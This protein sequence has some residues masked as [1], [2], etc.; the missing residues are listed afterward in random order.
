MDA[1][2]LAAYQ[3]TEYR[4]RDGAYAF[5][6]RVEEPSPLLQACQ[7][8][9]GVTCSAFL[10]ACNPHSTPTPRDVNEAAMARLE[11]DLAGMGLRWLRGMGVDPAGDWPGEP[12]LLV[13]GLDQPAGVALARRLAQNAIVC[14]AADAVPHL[15]I[16]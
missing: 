12:S 10:T 6:M 3:R 14:A 2:L 4:V 15:V 11:Q 5:V 8:S 13:L 9:F 16:C 1:E 7:E